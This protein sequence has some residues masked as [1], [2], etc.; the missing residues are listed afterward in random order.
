MEEDDKYEETEDEG[1]ENDPDAEIGYSEH[2]DQM[3]KYLEDQFSN[4]LKLAEQMANNLIYF[5]RKVLHSV[6]KKK[7]AKGKVRDSPMGKSEASTMADKFLEW[8]RR[9][10]RKTV[11]WEIVDNSSILSTIYPMKQ[12][13]RFTLVQAECTGNQEN[14]TTAV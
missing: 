1:E 8:R 13:G 12:V 14:F 2:M 3:Q 11:N 4:H 7:V 9:P 5:D 6:S 10:E